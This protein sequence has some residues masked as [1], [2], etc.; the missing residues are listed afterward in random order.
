MSKPK[1]RIVLVEDNETDVLLVRRALAQYEIDCE[2]E[3][4]ADGERA[5]AAILGWVSKPG[6]VLPSLVLLD[7]N[8]PRVDGFEL[9][10]LIRSR[11]DLDGVRV[12]I[13]T[14]SHSPA[15][16]G[17]ARELRADA[18]IIKPPSL[19]SF[20]TEVGTMI[21]ELLRRK[22]PNHHDGDAHAA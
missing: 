17:R 5:E 22:R 20:L 8:L 21:R 13:L 4:W 16:M 2:V 10:R 11:R 19:E 18:Y 6:M 9:L 7:L 1:P 12:A 3:H 14:S 15:D